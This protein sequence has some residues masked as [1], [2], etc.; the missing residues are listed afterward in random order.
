MKNILVPIDP[1]DASGHVLAAA[2]GLA[3][4]W[5]SNQ[6]L[7]RVGAPEPDFVGYDV[8]P[9]YVREQR[10]ETLRQEHVDL[11]AWAAD[12]TTKGIAAE[13]L[14][15]Q[16]PTAE[17]I[18]LQADRLSAG[19]IVV[20]SHAWGAPAKAFLGSVSGKVL[21]QSTVPVFVVPYAHNV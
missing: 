14:L 2:E 18:L 21:R 20:R 4:S 5:G 6:G 19:M 16:D 8:G 11:Q 15:A 10:A 17:T 3:R 12:S 9:Q 13:A 7:V 1:T